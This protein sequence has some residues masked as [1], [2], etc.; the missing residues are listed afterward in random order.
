MVRVSAFQISN[1]VALSILVEADDL[2]R[3]SVTHFVNRNRFAACLAHG[4]EKAKRAEPAATAT[5]CLPLM[6]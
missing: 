2:S 4:K 3:C 6:A 5:Y 1:P